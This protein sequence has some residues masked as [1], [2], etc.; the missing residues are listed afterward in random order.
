MCT[1]RG[2]RHERWGPVA[3]G[4]ELGPAASTVHAVLVRCR[5]NRLSRLDRVT[6][7]AIRRY[8]HPAPGDLLYV[9]VKKLGNVPTAAAGAWRSMLRTGVPWRTR[10]H[11]R[12]PRELMCQT[13]VSRDHP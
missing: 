5:L 11:N 1:P 3:I 2:R 4:D 12:V 6:G 9:D 7:E 10:S 13:R 8:E